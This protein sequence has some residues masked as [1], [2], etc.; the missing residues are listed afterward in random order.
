MEIG[1]PKLQF[2]L[3]F[4]LILAGTNQICA[5]DLSQSLSAWR[6]DHGTWF[7][8]G[9]AYMN[10]DNS[11]FLST[12]PGSSVFVNGADGRTKH[13]VSDEEFGDMRLHIEFLVPRGSNSGVYFMGRYEIQVRDSWGDD[14]HYPGNECGG[15]YQRWDESRKDKGYEGRSPLFH[16][17][18]PPGQW[19]W[20]DVLF[21]APRFN[22][23]SE[24][25]KNALFEKVYHNGTLVHE[26]FEVTGPTRSSM[27]EDEQLTG[28]IQLQGDHGPVAYRNIRV[29][30]A[31]VNPFFAMDTS[32]KDVRHQTFEAQVK[33]LKDLGYDGMDHTGVDNLQQKLDILDRHGLRLYAVYLDVWADKEKQW[34]NKELEKAAQLLR[35][36]DV[37]LWV[38]IR[39]NDFKPSSNKGDDQAIAII[40]KLADIAAK[41]NLQV[42]LYPHSF[43]Y[44]QTVDDALRLVEK[45]DRPNVGLTFNLCH[46]LRV[47]NS[48]LEA[49]LKKA[50]PHLY[51]VTINGADYKGDWKQLIQPLDSGEFDVSNVIT[52]LKEIDYLGP[53]GL[54]GY[55]IGGDVQRNLKRSMSSWQEILKRLD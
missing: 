7:E 21:R 39:S 53:I 11:R 36:R 54:Q 35:G 5:G 42:A 17:A 51:M 47:D 32:V 6:S 16:A 49:T 45:A 2:I 46:W 14:S 18:A 20:F 12:L 48:D 9:A 55:G 25:V 22:A 38:P 30:P 13:L 34:F 15:I 44:M 43:F 50:A 52:I 23:S 28:P 31:D 26:N 29:S 33:M 37:L 41:N 10:P 24:K 3:I 27:F 40:Q 8:A 4:F 1:M 19:Q